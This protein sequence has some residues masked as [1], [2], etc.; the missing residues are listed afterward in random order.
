[1][2]LKPGDVLYLRAGTFTQEDQFSAILSFYNVP[3][4]TKGAPI[5]VVAYP[6]E[7]VTLGDGTLQRGLSFYT[8]DNGPALDYLTIAK[9]VFLPTCDAVELINGD[10]GR[11]VGNDISGASDACENGVVEAQGTK[12]WK[13]LGNHIHHN[14]NT[15]LEHGI[16]LGGYGDNSGFEIAYNR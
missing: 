5:A 15:K 2:A 16:Y 11:F 9:L 4:G 14:G 8:G 6:G 7:V 10:N 1:D 3:P 13:I 12:G